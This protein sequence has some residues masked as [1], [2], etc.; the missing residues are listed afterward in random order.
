MLATT[1]TVN[2]DERINDVSIW[3]GV[4]S[5]R[6]CD[7][8]CTINRYWWWWW[9]SW[10]YEWKKTPYSYDD[11]DD[12]DYDSACRDRSENTSDDRTMMMPCHGANRR[13]SQC[14]GHQYL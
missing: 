6:R 2:Y 9:W 3:S 1:T 14:V 4:D 5:D 13:V 7:R 12:D 8:R 10:Q 11:D